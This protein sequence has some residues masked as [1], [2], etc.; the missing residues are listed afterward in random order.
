VA[1]EVARS[2]RKRMTPHEVKLWCQLR[3]LNQQ[4]FH[5]R[6]QAPV[7][8]YIVDFL[9][10]KRHIVVEVDGSQHGFLPNEIADRKRDTALKN[11]GYKVLRFWNVDI[12]HAM[13]G[14]MIKILENLHSP[15]LF[16]SR[17]LSSP[18]VGEE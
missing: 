18:V 2:L 4:G 6:R 9:E 14:V 12:D 15:L 5:F 8:G 7:L 17:E 3:Y 11:R 16:A 13:Y 1:N 10:K